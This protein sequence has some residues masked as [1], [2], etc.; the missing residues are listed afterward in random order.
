MKKKYEYTISKL[1]SEILSLKYGIENVEKEAK[2][3]M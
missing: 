1:I 2:D 3:K